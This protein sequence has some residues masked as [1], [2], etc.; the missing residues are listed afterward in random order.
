MTGALA[1]RL[2]FGRAA[3]AAECSSWCEIAGAAWGSCLTAWSTSIDLIDLK[4]ERWAHT[5]DEWFPLPAFDEIAVE[6]V[7]S[8]DHAGASECLDRG[9]V[10]QDVM[11]RPRDIRAVGRRWQ[12]LVEDSEQQQRAFAHRRNWSGA[13]ERGIPL[14]IERRP[15]QRHQVEQDEAEA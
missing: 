10:A 12:V 2:G 15:D 8:R 13:D 11:L 7:R 9:G 5:I 4:P 14:L 1:I 6:S 3:P